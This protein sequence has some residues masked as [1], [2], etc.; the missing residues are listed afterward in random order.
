MK[1][2]LFK[3]TIKTR[4]YTDLWI[5]V[6]YYANLFIDFEFRKI[7]AKRCSWSQGGFESFDTA[8]E[9][10]LLDEKCQG[11]FGAGCIG[12]YFHRCLIGTAYIP[13]KGDYS[14]PDCVYE[15]PCKLILKFIYYI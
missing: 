9:E 10:C 3:C 6:Q 5:S 13:D 14:K 7:S 8:K 11:F 12:N 15:K 2:K 1:G 4:E